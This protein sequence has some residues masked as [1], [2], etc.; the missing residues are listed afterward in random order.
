MLVK[1]AWR[2]IWRN[3]RRSL[4]T[5]ASVS[6]ALFF[7]IVMRSMQLGVYDQAYSSVIN[8]TTGYL[9][10]QGKGYW[11][12]PSLDRTFSP[13][14]F[15]REKI[16]AHDKVENLLPRLESFALL[17]SSK[18]ETKPGFLRG[19][20]SDLEARY[21]ELDEKLIAGNLPKQGQSGVVLASTLAENLRLKLGDTLVIIGQG[22]RGMS[23]NGKFAVIGIADLKNPEANKS[24]VYMDLNELQF[25]T[26]AF[27]QVSSEVII[28]VEPEKLNQIKAK[29]QNLL[30][31]SNGEV[32]SWRDMMPELIE[33]ME[34][35]SAGGLAI[36]FI[37]YMVIGFGMFG[38]ILMLTA[39]RKPEF[40]ILLSIGMSRARLAWSTFMEI[41]F[42]NLL[43]IGS[44][45]LLAL[46]I[47]AYYH[48]N[49]IQ[50][51]GDMGAMTEEYGM[52]PILPFSLDANIWFTHGGIVL[53]ISLLISLYAFITIY[54]VNPVNAMRR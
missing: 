45:G 4:I 50:L 23:A 43:G 29:L 25:L 12:K 52:E 9:Q 28:P 35:D 34:A 10:W 54:R 30:A 27:G 19:V 37:L 17:A 5:I 31:T 40:G 11:E 51:Q 47:A 1:I 26:G 21:F 16:I 41:A 14:S 53:I 32:L 2:N 42:L 15:L 48:Y 18:S 20:K 24:T 46:P 8:A 44:G 49:P 36:L 6:F 38:T 3:K 13:D 7:A 33:A 22:Y 39:E